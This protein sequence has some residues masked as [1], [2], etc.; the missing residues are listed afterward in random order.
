MAA[1]EVWGRGAFDDKASLVSLMEA[2]E[3]LIERGFSPRR[4]IYLAFG[5]D[6][7]AGG[8]SGAR[9]I[10][11]LLDKRGVRPEFVLDE[12]GAVSRGLVPAVPGT[13]ATAAVAEKGYV[14]VELNAS[15]TGGHSS[16]PSLTTAIGILSRAVNRVESNPMPARLVP[17]VKATL[18]FIAPEAPFARRLVLGNLWATSGL[19]R[20]FMQRSPSGNAQVRTTCVATILRA[21]SKSNV[22][23]G[24]AQA[25]VN[26][27]IL[28]GDS[29]AS[30]VSHIEG[31]VGDPNVRVKRREGSG[32]EPSPVSSVDSP[33]GLL[34]RKTIAETFPDTAFAPIM[35]TAGTDARY[36][37]RLSDSVYRFIPFTATPETLQLIHGTNERVSV[38]EC[39]RAVRFY[40]QLLTNACR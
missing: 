12:G 30:V 22:I 25:I 14:D 7:E 23:P 6:E 28:P 32:R 16:A 18:E 37:T 11:E 27:R 38:K 3:S 19:V 36:Y 39:E 8:G 2:I 10:A 40:A 35:T 1:G 21:G 4:T 29:V 17:P 15:A 31:V 9:R 13:V 26:C 34:L 5:H 33:G 24:S 20:S